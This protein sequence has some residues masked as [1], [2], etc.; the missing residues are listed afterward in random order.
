MGARHE[1]P[2]G[3]AVPPDAVAHPG[4]DQVKP[5]R[6]R[7][8][9]FSLLAFLVIL[10]VVPLALAEAPGAPLHGL[11]P[12]PADPQVPHQLLPPGSLDPDDGPSDVIFPSQHITIRFNHAKHM[13]KPIGLTCKTCHGAAFRSAS[14]QDV[15][16]PKG[17]TCD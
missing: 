15:L 9:A 6:G 8:L 10:A 11:A 12:L 4:G 1:R 14:A 13:Q 16:I 2:G 17:S 5:S 7:G 3:T